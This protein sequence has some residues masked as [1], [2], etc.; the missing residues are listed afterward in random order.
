MKFS[1]SAPAKINR[2]LRVGRVRADGF[3]EVRSRMVSISLAD[4]ITVEPASSLEFHCDDPAIP[5][6]SEN[7][8]VRAAERLAARAGVPPRARI[9]LE[10][11]TPAGGG[12]GGGSADAAIT[13]RLLARLWGLAAPPDLLSTVASEL[14]SDVPFFLSGG[15]ADVTGRGEVVAGVPDG[16]SA[17]LL[18]L[19]PPFSISTAAVYRAHAGRFALAPSLAVESPGHTGY[20]GPNDLASAVLEIEPRMQPYLDSAA[21]MTPD[22]AISGSG[23]TIVLHGASAAAQRHLA[24]RHPDA[25]ILPCRTLSHDDYQQASSPRGGPR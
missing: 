25:R 15:Q 5:P 12:L 13:L 6:G 8:V 4:G 20:L 24:T 2:E 16:P 11:R 17:D 1:A 18:L 10:K 23:A 14:G 9:V 22:H 21:A 7:L 3:H 19:V